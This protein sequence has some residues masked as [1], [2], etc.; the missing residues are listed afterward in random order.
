[1]VLLSRLAQRNHAKV[2]YCYTERLRWGRGFRMHII[3]ASED[4]YHSDKLHSATALNN[5][6]ERCIGCALCAAACPACLIVLW[7]L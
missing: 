7:P 2:L 5:G 1:M 3:P 4:I 6:L